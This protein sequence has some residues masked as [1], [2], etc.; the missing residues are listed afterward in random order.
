[1]SASDTKQRVKRHFL[2]ED[3]VMT[4]VATE[5]SLDHYEAAV[6]EIIA[7]CNGDMRGA[8]KALMLVNEQLETEL[9]QL[10]E[11]ARSGPRREHRGK[12][13]FH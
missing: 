3:L 6:D 13:L 12:I 9:Q 8:V 7:S 5:F 4:R 10:N 1:V 11:A 2:L